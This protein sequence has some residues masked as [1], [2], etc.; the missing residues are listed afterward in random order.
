MAGGS[1][2]WLGPTGPYWEALGGEEGFPLS[3]P[4]QQ[5]GL[6]GLSPSLL[7]SPPPPGPPDEVIKGGLGGGGDNVCPCVR[8]CVPSSVSPC[9]RPPALF[10]DVYLSPQVGTVT[11]PPAVSQTHPHP[12]VPSP[13]PPVS[14]T[15][16]GDTTVP[17]GPSSGTTGGGSRWQPRVLGGGLGDGGDTVGTVGMGTGCPPP[18]KEE[19]CERVHHV[20]PPQPKSLHQVGTWGQRWGGTWGPQGG[21]GHRDPEGDMGAWA[22]PRKDGDMGTVRGTQGPQ[23]GWRHWGGYGDSGREMGTPGRWGAW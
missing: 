5:G 3:P 23:E 12:H 17:A 9:R 18:A 21:W 4:K 10:A 13:H 1:N 14:H 8:V 6:L 19:M 22:V 15:P 11:P 2:P 20:L 16:P 7:A